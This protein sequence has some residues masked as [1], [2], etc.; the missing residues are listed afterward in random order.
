MTDVPAVVKRFLEYV[1]ID[2][3]ADPQSDSVPSSDGQIV[4]GHLIAGQLKA[5]GAEDVH[6]DRNGY[7]YA[8]IAPSPGYRGP[9]LGLLAHLDTSPDAPGQNVKPIVHPPYDGGTI[10]FKGNPAIVLDPDQQPALLKHI[11]HRIITSDG[12]TLLGS[13]DKAGVAIIMQLA[14]DLLTQPDLPRPDL[15]LCFTID[16]ELG[17]GIDHIH[18]ERFGAE[19]AYTID[20]SS[21]DVIYCETFNAASAVVTFR[22][23]GVHPGYA[24]GTMVNAVRALARFI[25]SLPKDAAPETTREREGYIHPHSVDASDVNRASVHLILRDFDLDA[26]EQRIE[27]LKQLAGDAAD[28]VSGCDVTVDVTYEYSNM[29]RAI[30]EIDPR[31]RSFAYEAARELGIDLNEAPVRGGTDGAR[32]SERGIPTP[33][34]FNGGHDYHSLFEWNTVENME[35]SLAYLHALTARWSRL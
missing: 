2:T 17:K 10:S 8:R 21:T 31:V 27:R 7:V 25:D 22:G 35:H 18:L 23:I 33:N 14:E 24:Y 3:T 20:G 13:D 32:L 29:A 28:S 9:A 26:L 15:R 30:D 4:L 34:V 19:V 12:T 11:G 1:R 6:H 16:E 5:L